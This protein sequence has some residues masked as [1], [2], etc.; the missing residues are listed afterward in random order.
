MSTIIWGK[1]KGK[2]C[3]P[4]YSDTKI[5]T[6]CTFVLEWGFI[7][8]KTEKMKSLPALHKVPYNKYETGKWT[9]R[10]NVDKW[11]NCLQRN[12]H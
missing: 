3:L 6:R 5:E 12:S 4:L 7:Q 10:E 9:Q 2:S 11:Q 8:G 1:K